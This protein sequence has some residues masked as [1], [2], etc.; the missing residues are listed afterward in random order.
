MRVNQQIYRTPQ[1]GVLTEGD[2]KA[3]YSASLEVLERTGVRME[4]EEVLSLLKDNGACIK[5][6]IAHIPSYLVE[7]SL[8]Y[9]PKKIL[10][11]S[12]EGKLAMKLEGTNSYFGTGSD[13]PNIIDS[14]SGKLRKQTRK[15]IGQGALIADALANID[16]VMSMGLISDEPMPVT[17]LYQFQEMVFNTT[18][19]IVFT[20]HDKRGNQDIIDMASIIAGGEDKLRQ[21]PFIIHYIEP[22][23]PLKHSRAA[24][25]KLLL[26][27]EKQIPI[28]YTPCTSG[29]A[30]APVTLA[31]NIVL[32]LAEGLA[33]VVVSQLKN[34]GTPIILGGV[35]TVMDMRTTTFCYGAPEFYL[36]SAGLA[37]VC[38]FLD[39]PVF[40]TAG[41]T[42]S[43]VLD[44]QAAIEA[45]LSI[46]I[47]S[48]SGANLIHDVGYMASAM[49]GS[50]DMLVMSDE[51]IAM[52]KRI[53]RGISV[54]EESLCVDVI[55]KVGPGGNYL[56]EEHT[57]RHFRTEYW[58]PQLLDRS[59]YHVW[60]GK[61]SKSLNQKV[62]EKVKS[63]FKERQLRPLDKQKA[64]QILQLIAKEEKVRKVK[65]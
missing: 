15:D 54:D 63:I 21:K 10:I 26:C 62:N 12:R 29:G 57:L 13:C 46:I 5:G 47:E 1:F 58:R 32:A 55:D 38:Q 25:D 3:I 14:F 9:A 44:E 50:F 18:K 20:S 34:K 17:D 60:A 4:N 39:M 7:E 56:T 61:G 16:F 35:I 49:T 27:S 24:L 53:M 28:I 40:G 65:W 33:G 41:C 42:D 22:S 36:L 2:C 6:D 59:S 31:G 48:L 8:R 51:I 23:S 30:T 37:K 45:S 43:K 19:P 11:Y 52:V 64:N